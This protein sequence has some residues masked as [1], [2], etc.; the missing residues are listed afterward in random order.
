M[1][2]SLKD[3]STIANDATFQGR[4]LGAATIAA[5]SVMTEA[6]TTPNHTARVEYC[7]Q[8]LGGQVPASRIALAVVTINTV[9]AAGDVTLLT[10]TAGV[11]DAVLQAAVNTALPSMA[12]IAS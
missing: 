8:I 10:T 1:A 11:S 7:R 9:I 12:G 2:A 4:C 3:A 5:M 6:G